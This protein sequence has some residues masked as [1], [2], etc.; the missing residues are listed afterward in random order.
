[1]SN[2]NCQKFK[3]EIENYPG[4]GIHNTESTVGAAFLK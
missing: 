1:M 3:G 2:T 4:N